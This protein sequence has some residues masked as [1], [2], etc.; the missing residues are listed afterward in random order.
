MTL[1]CYHG[2]IP[3]KINQDRADEILEV[4][5]NLEH[6]M[7]INCIKNESKSVFQ[8]SEDTGITKSTIY[9]RIRELNKKKLLILSGEINSHKR[10]VV[11]Y[12]SKICKIMV[13]LDKDMMDVTIFSNLKN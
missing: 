12:K 5:T 13:I 3:Y 10:K 8:I 7:I 1:V 11:K 4:M 9:R 6:R 2:E